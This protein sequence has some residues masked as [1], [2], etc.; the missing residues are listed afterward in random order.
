[1]SAYM[2]D[3][4]TINKVLAYLSNH[5]QHEYLVQLLKEN[6]YDVTNKVGLVRLGVRMFALNALGVN[7]RYGREQAQEF[8]TLEYTF[9]H[10]IPPSTIQAHK[11]LS[12]WLYQCSEG[13]VP[14]TKLYKLMQQVKHL[15]AEDIVQSLPAYNLAKWG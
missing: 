12:C 4:S 3:D 13:K 1:M 11:S 7:A 15:I 5:N 2:V 14:E 10:T 8:R 6:G 9:Q